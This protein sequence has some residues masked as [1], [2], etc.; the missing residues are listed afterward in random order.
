MSTLDEIVTLPSGAQL[1]LKP[2]PWAVAMKLLK[3]VASEIQGVSVGLKLELNFANP[4]AA[5]AKLMAQDVPLD[6]F[7]NAACVAISSEQVELAI[8]HCM[9]SCLYEG[10]A[11]AKTAETFEPQDARQDYLPA[12]WEVM[13]FNLA[14]FFKG[15]RSRSPSPSGQPGAS[16]G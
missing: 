15:L 12:A 11:I 4:A 2:A 13:R 16:P 3:T 7:K 6:L 8:A 10:R 1:T 9:R 14:P 5:I